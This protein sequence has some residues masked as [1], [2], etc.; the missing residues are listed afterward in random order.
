MLANP[1]MFENYSC[2]LYFPSDGCFPR[3]VH[4]QFP[5][6]YLRKQPYSIISIE[7]TKSKR[8][9]GWRGE[10]ERN[11]RVQRRKQN[12]WNDSKENIYILLPH[13]N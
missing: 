12:I 4:K 8:V 11:M 1:A 10:W 3:D 9:K 13:P 2:L 5:G 7:G 6:Y